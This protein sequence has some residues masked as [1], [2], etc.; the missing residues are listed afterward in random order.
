M[1]IELAHELQ[2]VGCLECQC[3]VD[4]VDAAP[5]LVTFCV[6]CGEDEPRLRVSCS[7]GHKSQEVLAAVL[8]DLG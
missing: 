3:P 5:H 2:R 8:E 6:S 1:R 7:E 4:D